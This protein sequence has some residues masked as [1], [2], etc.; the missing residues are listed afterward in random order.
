ML[1][2]ALLITVT[3]ALLLAPPQYE[4]GF[5]NYGKESDNTRVFFYFCSIVNLMFIASI[6]T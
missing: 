1:V 4:I 3:T 2:S 6:I 5:R